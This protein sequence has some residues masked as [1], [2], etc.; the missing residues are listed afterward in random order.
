MIPD[1][2]SFRHLWNILMLVAITYSAIEAPLRL[3]IKPPPSI[4]LHVADLLITLLFVADIILHFRFSVLRGGR[5]VSDRNTVA[6]RYLRTWFAWDLIA[7]L[8]FD[9]L[10]GFFL[11][12]GRF[13]LLMRIVHLGRLAKLVRIFYYRDYFGYF[14][15]INFSIFRLLFFT[16]LIGLTSHWIACGWYHLTVNEAQISNYYSAYLNSLYWC[17]TTLT[18]VGYGDLTPHSNL[19]KIYTMIVMILGVGVYGYVIGNV[20]NII[21]SLDVGKAQHQERVEKIN[22]FMIDH[23]FTSDLQRRVKNYFSYL[24]DS[25]RGYDQASVFADLPESFKIEFALQ[26]NRDIIAKV[27]LFRGADKK[28]IQ[29]IVMI[30]KPCIYLPSDL[31]CTFGE[32]GDKMYFINKGAVEVVAP[33]GKD[34]YNTLTG[35]GFFGEVALLMSTPRNAT[36][37]AV[38]YC[39]LYSLDKKD[40]DRVIGDYP[41]FAKQI[42]AEARKRM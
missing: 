15:N 30:L 19:E 39:E 17:V 8:P 22:A 1:K 31:I 32:I 12:A 26:L 2:N 38:D 11:P 5:W 13:F 25:R 28:L 18:T 29:N 4:W 35:G 14:L 7:A 20:A 36:V 41:E 10:I 3:V 9:L 40:F 16:Y 27:P 33:N 37:R 42:K 21:S 23:K 34:V 24:W 6:K